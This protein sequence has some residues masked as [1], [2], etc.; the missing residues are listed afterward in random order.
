MPTLAETARREA[1]EAEAEEAEQQPDQ[2][3]QSEGDEEQAP[4]VEP[5]PGEG[6][7]EPS[8]A[9]IAELRAACDEHADHV[10]AIMGPFVDGFV[11]CE[12]CNGIGI[13]YP[14][15]QAPKRETKA[16]TQECPVCKGYGDLELPTKRQGFE[17][18][19]CDNCN[20]KGWV[21]RGNLP[22]TAAAAAAVAEYPANDQAAAVAQQPG[23]PESTDPRVAELRAAGYIVLD[24]PGG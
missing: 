23:Q 22:P 18:E 9:M 16:G 21:G 14:Q 4:P 24:R 2:D 19:Q 5:H 20:G 8:D 15:P 7:E 11:T 10:H 3:D 1:E 13:A 17:L 12:T 6:L